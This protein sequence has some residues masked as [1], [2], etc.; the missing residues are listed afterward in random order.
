M[1]RNPPTSPSSAAGLVKSLRVVCM[2]K[3]VSLSIALALLVM[4]SVASGQENEA[5]AWILPT[6]S[7]SFFYADHLTAATYYQFNPDGTYLATAKEHMGVWPVDG[8]TWIQASDGVMTLTSTNSKR[9]ARGPEVVKP[10]QYRDKVF[11]VWPAVS[12]KA[13]PASVC[14][15]ID[16]PT[17][18]LPLFNEFMITEAE[19]RNGVGKPYAF[20]FHPELNKAT[21]AE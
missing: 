8:G 6:N 10:M 3:A 2:E 12:Y 21:G 11:L 14:R 9:A 20:K 13:D 15:F 7:P 5:R 4:V 1:K 19:F 18:A 17:N 16:S